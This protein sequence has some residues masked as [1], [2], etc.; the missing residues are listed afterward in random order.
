MKLKGK[1]AAQPQEKRPLK[2]R[3]RRMFGKRFFA[4][5]YSVFAAAVVIAIAVAVNL[6]AG[7]LPT[8]KTEI[9]LTSQAIFT[10]SDQ[11]RRIVSGVDQ[12]VK[13]YLLAQSGSENDTVVRLLE[14][15]ASLN[16][17]IKVQY[18]DPNEKPTFL[19]QYDLGSTPL[20]ANSVLVES[21][22]RTKLVGYDEI[23]VTSYSMDYYSYSYTT[24]T[25]FDGE[26]A[27]TNAIHYVTSEDI[28]KVYTLTGHG[29]NE[30]SDTLNT[31]IERD[32]METGTLSLLMIED[33]PEDAGVVVI[34]APTSD[35][36]S[37]EADMLIRYLEDG[38]RVVL[39]T[40]Y[41]ES[42][43]M[44]NLLRVTAKMGMT[45]GQGLIVE[46]DRSM[47]L[48]R[49][50]YYLLPDIASHD[51]TEPLIEGR[52]Y[53]LAPLAQPILETEDSDA[54]VSPMLKT[55]DS[56]YAKAA[57]LALETTEKEEGDA[58]GAFMVAAASELGEGRMVWIAS[59]MLM[60]DNVNAMVSGGNSDLFMN[61]LDWMC[62]QQETI[63]IRS[64]S[65]DEQGLTLTQAQSSFWNVVMLGMIPGAILVVGIVVVMRRKRR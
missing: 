13:L 58:D 47:H 27:L 56:A 52:Y 60:E 24:S 28:P 45:A 5:S 39:V 23:F 18:I 7:A 9:D 20:Y 42:G 34:N 25:S 26:N 48:S 51:I 65:M 1:K 8:D 37:D 35:L 36:S 30:L 2:E 19:D 17:R 15:Y 46:G 31:L 59:A 49:Y 44:E 41:I 64:K 61:S 43:E 21:G 53:V 32:N 62:D 16:D 11:T 12:E 55:S 14:R 54:A 22:E 50:P 3:V 10:L 29:E 4:G 6:M 38:G 40:D 33:V 57:G 63:S